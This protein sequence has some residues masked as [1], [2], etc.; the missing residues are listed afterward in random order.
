MLTATEA[1]HIF[2]TSGAIVRGHFLL[3]SGRHGD[4]YVVKDLVFA[5]PE[6][7]ILFATTIVRR[8][9]DLSRSHFVDVVVGHMN[10]GGIFA[11]YVAQEF[12]YS[13]IAKPLVV[14]VERDELGVSR[15][16][17][18]YDKLVSEKRCLVVEDVLTSG[19]TTRKVI[20]LVLAAGGTV[21]GVAAMCNRGG[22]TAA[23]LGIP[24]LPF[25]TLFDY[26]LETWTP[27][28]CPQCQ[29]GVPLSTELG[30]G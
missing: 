15:L 11:H 28:E 21:L 20:E 16:R 2:E 23:Q 1:L 13:K 29:R 19:D 12:L 3:S 5:Q 18:G 14:Y 25:I 17:R 7:C 9:I 22:V 30:K 26:P 6:Q 24:E 10:G 4:V 27:E 8:L